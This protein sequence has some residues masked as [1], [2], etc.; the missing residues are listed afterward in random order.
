MRDITNDPAAE[1]WGREVNVLGRSSFICL[2][3]NPLCSLVLSYQR[4]HSV[5]L[6]GWEGERG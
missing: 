5:G 4:Y 6:V 2:G 1:G 3:P